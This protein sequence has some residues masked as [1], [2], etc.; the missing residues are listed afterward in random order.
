MVNDPPTWCRVSGRLFLLSGTA[1]ASIISRMPP[2]W[3]PWYPAAKFKGW[4]D[5]PV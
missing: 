5:G 2:G 1:L 4:D 3:Y